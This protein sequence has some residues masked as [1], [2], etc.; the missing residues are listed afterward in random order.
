M[1]EPVINDNTHNY[2]HALHAC[3]NYVEHLGSAL[4]LCC[5]FLLYKVI[6]YGGKS[7][8]VFLNL[9]NIRVLG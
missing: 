9:R 1:V 6:G 8:R 5:L 7:R 4:P 3:W 2:I